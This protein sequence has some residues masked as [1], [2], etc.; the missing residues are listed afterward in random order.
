MEL[1]GSNT[2]LQPLL[3]VKQSPLYG[4]VIQWTAVCSAATSESLDDMSHLDKNFNKYVL[5][6][7]SNYIF[8][9]KCR[10]KYKNRVTFNVIPNR[11]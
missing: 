5:F 4:G 9:V 8:V 7:R 10:I 1:T 11:Y 6:E 3:M 2:I